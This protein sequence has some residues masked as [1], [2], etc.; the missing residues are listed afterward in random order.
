MSVSTGA[1]GTEDR[2]AWLLGTDETAPRPLDPDDF[3]PACQFVLAKWQV[4]PVAAPRLLAVLT[5][6]QLEHPVLQQIRDLVNAVSALARIQVL[7]A[8]RFA[9]ALEAERVPYTFLKGSAVRLTAYPDIGSRGGLDVD[10]GVPSKFLS[11]AEGIA[12]Q[13]GFRPASLDAAGRHFFEVSAYERALVEADHYELACLV[14]R[15]VVTNLAPDV[16]TAIRNSIPILRPWHVT[17]EG[18]LACYV[19]LDVHHGLCLDIQVDSIVA[20]AQKRRIGVYRARIP[21]PE[22]LLFHL[23]FKIYWEGVHN[24]RK[25]AYQY[26]DVVR[27]I[28]QIQGRSAIALLELLSE[29]RLEAAGFYVLRRLE[30]DFGLVLSPELRNFLTRTAIPPTDEFPNNVNDMGD[31]WPKIWGFR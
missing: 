17:K 24:Y 30:S 2:F 9:R 4:S 13:Q 19:T 3:E 26:A 22:W 10:V 21:R 1:P 23:I 11:R 6:E 29:Y 16:D 25:G 14:R 28:G 15:Q 18:Q 27:L 8:D 12:S 20:S 7:L 5:P 31:M